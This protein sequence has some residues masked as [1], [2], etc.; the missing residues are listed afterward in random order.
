MNFKS[1]EPQVPLNDDYWTLFVKNSG[2]WESLD[3]GERGDILAGPVIRHDFAHSR[4]RVGDIEKPQ[5]IARILAERGHEPKSASHF[6]LLRLIQICNLIGPVHGPEAPAH[7][8]LAARLAEHVLDRKVAEAYAVEK[9]MSRWHGNAT[10]PPVIDLSRVTKPGRLRRL[11]AIPE[12]GNGIEWEK[13]VVNF[14][15]HGFPSMLSG[16]VVFQ[17]TR[18]ILRRLIDHGGPM[19][20]AKL[21]DA[22]E[23]NRAKQSNLMGKAIRSLVQHMLMVV[24]YD[25]EAGGLRA[26]L[27]PGVAE[28]IRLKEGATISLP[29]AASEPKEHFSTVLLARDLEVLLADALRSPLQV[30]VS[31]ALEIY[32]A[33][34]RRIAE[35]L[36]PVPDWFDPGN[37]Y[38]TKIRPQIAVAVAYCLD[39]LELDSNKWLRVTA[40]GNKHLKASPAQR[41]NAL[42]DA[43]RARG[44]SAG[45]PMAW[46]FSANYSEFVQPNQSGKVIDADKAMAKAWRQLPHDRWLA[47]DKWL[48]YLTYHQNPVEM[49]VGKDG[50]CGVVVPNSWSG[51]AIKSIYGEDIGERARPWIERFLYTRLVPLGAVELGRGPKGSLL[52]RLTPLGRYFLGESDR[53]PEMESPADGRV[54]LQP[55]FEI[56]FLGP[57]IVARATVARFAE[58][59]APAKTTGTLFRLTKSS[60]Q[61]YLHEHKPANGAESILADLRE[62]CGGTLPANVVAEIQS[63]AASRREYILRQAIAMTLPDKVTTML[64]HGILKT[65]SIIVSD[66]TLLLD[67]PPTTAEKKKLAKVG[68][69]PSMDFGSASSRKQTTG[70]QS[71]KSGPA[72]DDFEDDI[73]DDF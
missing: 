6:E 45:H 28:L 5:A 29:P 47:V 71:R 9:P 3:A 12:G 67:R 19:P 10:P 36:E 26:G 54:V 23:F 1:K 53:F 8:A 7:A 49:A 35:Q 46:N 42:L 59:I 68:I 64:A 21:I 50:L 55:N 63:W 15:D 31:G 25:T 2:L 18:V 16:T 73:I 51:Y 44:M 69:F 56:V 61:K 32:A 40:K 72:W 22:T 43:I 4:L 48:D 13:S 20:L 66:T 24:D 11:L 70:S 65:C 30:K 14:H 41:L 38:D 62:V 60:I 37:R 34:A 17:L 33:N 27:W 39:Y 58:D 57:N 52:L